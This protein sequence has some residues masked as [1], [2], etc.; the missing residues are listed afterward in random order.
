MQHKQSMDSDGDGMID[1][2]DMGDA[3]I[4]S[5]TLYNHKEDQD[6]NAVILQD[7]KIINPVGKGA[8][9]KVYLVHCSKEGQFYAM[10][11]IR[12]DMIIDSDSIANLKLEKQ[13]LLQNHH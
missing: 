3:S 10:K 8:F 1:D 9:G 11:S 4:K 2:S 7:F 13:I 6:E 5:T 12:K